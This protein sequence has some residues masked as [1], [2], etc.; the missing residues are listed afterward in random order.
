M[1]TYLSST[2]SKMLNSGQCLINFLNRHGDSD[3]YTLQQR[4]DNDEGI[5]FN[6]CC[7]S[8]SNIGLHYLNLLC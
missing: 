6:T 5:H 2:L 7:S 3:A 1:A 4:K 8:P